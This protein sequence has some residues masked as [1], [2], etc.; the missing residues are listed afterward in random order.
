VCCRFGE[1]DGG[2]LICLDVG[3]GDPGA[4]YLW[5]H[6]ILPEDAAY[7]RLADDVDALIEALEPR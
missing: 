7:A 1:D 6:E 3:A 4:V 2:N 5:E